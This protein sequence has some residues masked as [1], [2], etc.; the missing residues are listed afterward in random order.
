MRRENET[1]QVRGVIVS[2]GLTYNEVIGSTIWGEVYSLFFFFLRSSACPLIFRGKIDVDRL[3]L[4]GD[5]V[6]KTLRVKFE[7]VPFLVKK[8][9]ER[10]EAAAGKLAGT[11]ARGGAR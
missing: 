11:S 7:P 4:R 6:S 10:A 3:E 1:A 9:R 8:K 2:S 5:A